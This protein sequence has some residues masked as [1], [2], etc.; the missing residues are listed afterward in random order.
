[1]KHILFILTFLFSLN[2]A[3][4]QSETSGGFSRRL[5][6]DN[7]LTL[8][9][10]LVQSG[11]YLVKNTFTDFAGFYRGYY[12]GRFSF[13]DQLFAPPLPTYFYE[14]NSDFKNEKNL[15]F[16]RNTGLI[17]RMGYENTATNTNSYFNCSTLQCLINSNNATERST[18]TVVRNSLRSFY[19]NTPATFRNGSIADA[20]GY[21]MGYYANLTGVNQI[22]GISNKAGETRL[23]YKTEINNLP[24][25]QTNAQYQELSITDG[26]ANYYAKNNYQFNF[27][28]P[29]NTITNNAFVSI[30]NLSTQLGNSNLNVF[31]S[32]AVLPTVVLANYTAI[33]QDYILLV[34]NGATDITITLPNANTCTGRVYYIKR[35]D[36]TSTG[37]VTIASNSIESVTLFTFGATTTLGTT[38]TTRRVGFISNGTAWEIFSN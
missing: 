25:S 5:L 9:G 23:I 35:K 32:F 19:E 6:F 28:R 34:N 3:M 38:Q 31:G 18:I 4:A 11:G 26:A 16:I 30:N 8:T 29:N 20:N 22:N 10:N 12:G 33:A 14:I 21:Q 27:T 1:M 24:T 15:F 17:V 37:V 13:T 7:D 2:S 36:S